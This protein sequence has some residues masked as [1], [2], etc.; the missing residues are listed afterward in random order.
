MDQTYT[1]FNLIFAA[2]VLLVSFLLKKY[3]PK[4]INLFVGYRTKRS[5]ESTAA[6]LYANRYAS[7]LLYKYAWY[8]IG[9][10]VVLYF[11]FDAR[12]AYFAA[13]GLWLLSVMVIIAKTEHKLKTHA[14]DADSNSQ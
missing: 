3:Y 12:I 13:I 6:W 5:M 2:V 1:I 7:N 11:A 14:W 9:G 8:C 4:D 10:Q